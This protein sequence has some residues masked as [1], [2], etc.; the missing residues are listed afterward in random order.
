MRF[1]GAQHP[2][3]PQVFFRG[4]GPADFFYGLIAMSEHIGPLSAAGK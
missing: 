3:K 1:P 4:K 2:R